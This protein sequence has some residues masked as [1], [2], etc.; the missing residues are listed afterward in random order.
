VRRRSFKWLLVC[1]KKIIEASDCL[2]AVSDLLNFWL[3]YVQH[4]LSTRYLAGVQ[5]NLLLSTLIAGVQKG[6]Y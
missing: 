2:C 3:A 5:H 6:N 4:F 1:I